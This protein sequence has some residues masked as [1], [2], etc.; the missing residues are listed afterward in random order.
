LSAFAAEANCFMSDCFICKK[1]RALSEYTGPIIFEHG[2]LTLTHFPSVPDEKAVEGWLIVEPRR[3]IEHMSEM[4]E[5]E[6]AAL[7]LLLAK[8]ERL[9]KEKL[10][11]EHV[12][13]QRIN[14]K[15]AHLHFHL[16]PRYPDTPK[17]FWGRR[18]HEFPGFK[19]LSLAQIQGL[20]KELAEFNLS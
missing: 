15:V 8:A 18:I 10:G 4:N 13:L 1:H 12:Y 17:E 3:H 7:G 2:G 5:A 11:A 9:I 14:D 19:T 20:S 16:I 6:S